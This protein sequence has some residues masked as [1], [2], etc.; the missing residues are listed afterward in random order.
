MPAA[1][2]EMGGGKAVAQAAR[3]RRG[4]AARA[5]AGA[6]H[7]LR[8]HGCRRRRRAAP[9]QP[10]R[11]AG[12]APAAGPAPLRPDRGQPA[13]RVD[14]PQR[15]GHPHRAAP[16]HAGAPGRR[17]RRM[18][19]PVRPSAASA[20]GGTARRQQRPVPP[21]RRR[22]RTACR[23]ARRHAAARPG[24]AGR[25]PV[26]AHRSRRG[27]GAARDAGTARRLYLGRQRGTIRISGCWEW[28]T[29]SW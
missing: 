9:R 8:R 14:R 2:L 29:R 19:R 10:H 20:G 4:F 26:P 15:R 13:R 11:G 16:R 28:P 17:R 7:R 23:I 18:A 22:R 5:A 12:A 27:P 1:A 21:G 24:G 25:H 6:D 3:R